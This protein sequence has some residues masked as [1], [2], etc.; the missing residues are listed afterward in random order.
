MDINHDDIGKTIG[1]RLRQQR[2][3]NTIIIMTT[4][5]HHLGE[6]ALETPWRLGISGV[7]WMIKP[8][9]TLGYPQ[10]S[11]R[12][13]PHH[14]LGLPL[15]RHHVKRGLPSGAHPRVSI[16]HGYPKQSA[17]KNLVVEL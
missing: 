12:A 11:H 6:I 16:E 14:F 15:R 2:M 5:D 4:Y 17:G 1:L 13:P 3:Q 9:K 10:M 8:I 7:N